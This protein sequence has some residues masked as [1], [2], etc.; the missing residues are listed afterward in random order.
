MSKGTD[1]IKTNIKIRKGIFIFFKIIFSFNSA[2]YYVLW[3]KFLQVL[4]SPIDFFFALIEK[5]K[6]KSEQEN[7]IPILFVV[8]IQRTGST[9]VSQ[10]IEKTFPFFPIGNFNTIFKRS[11]YYVHKWI[12]R[13]YKKPNPTYKNFYGIA[14]GIFSIGDSYELW[15]RWLDKNHYLIPSEIRNEKSNHLKNY[16]STL[17]KAYNK[18]ILTKNNRNSLLIPLFKATFKNSFYVIVKRNPVSVIKSTLQASKDFFGNG[19]LLWGLYPTQEFDS[20]NYENLTEAATVQ[21]LM[22]NKI[23]NDQLNELEDDSYLVIDYN[24]FCKNPSQFQKNLI[25]KLNAKKNFHTDNVIFKEESFKTSERLNNSQIEI[26]IKEYL[27]K[28]ENKI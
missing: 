23:L 18:P 27:K 25:E 6:K 1:F 4:F 3:L 9:L 11:N 19:D 20:N 21:F 8:G 12:R 5:T 7:E 10:F 17:Y 16:F 15:D 22:L 2:A 28:W 14:K 24:D 26:Q 13:L